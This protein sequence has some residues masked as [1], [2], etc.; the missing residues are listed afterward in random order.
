VLRVELDALFVSKVMVVGVGTFGGRQV[1]CLSAIVV[2]NDDT[3]CFRG[4]RAGKLVVGVTIDGLS[5]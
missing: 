4:A 3:N 2:V 5:G 1:I